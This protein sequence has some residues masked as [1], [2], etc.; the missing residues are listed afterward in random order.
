MIEMSKKQA[1]FFAILIWLAVLTAAAIL[2][3]DFQIKGVILE[4][5]LEFRRHY[6]GWQSGQKG[7]ATTSKRPDNNRRNDLAYPSDLVASGH[8]VM[9]EASDNHISMEAG[10]AGTAR[11]ANSRRANDAGTIP[12]NGE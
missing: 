7:T 6:E 8:T 11:A 1:E 4:Q 3:I 9:E 12:G 5:V 2:I 10:S